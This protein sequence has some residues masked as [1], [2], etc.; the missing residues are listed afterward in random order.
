MTPKKTKISTF[1]L[2][3]LNSWCSGSDRPSPLGVKPASVPILMIKTLSQAQLLTVKFCVMK[4]YPSPA[5]GSRSSNQPRAFPT[6]CSAQKLPGLSGRTGLCRLSDVVAA[7]RAPVAAACCLARCR[8]V[9]S[10]QGHL[11]RLPTAVLRLRV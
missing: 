9:I 11:G 6:A 1:V 5:T 7:N 3:H 10:P 4:A 2:Q 8:P